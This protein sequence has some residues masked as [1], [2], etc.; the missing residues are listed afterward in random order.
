MAN[1][2]LLGFTG[3]GS[4]DD[5]FFEPIIERTFQQLVL[6]SPSQIEVFK[7]SYIRSDNGK[8]YVEKISHASKAAFSQGAMI[9]CVHTDADANTDTIAFDYKINPA[10]DYVKNSADE[11]C[12]NLCAIVPVYMTEAWLLADKELLKEELF[13]DK[14]N[15]VLGIEHHPE[16]Y[17]DPK[18][19]IQEAINVIHQDLPRK[20]R[21]LT[22][23]DLYQ[24]LGQKIPLEKLHYLLSYRKF[25]EAAKSALIQIN[26]LNP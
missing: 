25:W 21:S 12:K 1:I 5:R 7:P 13:T 16:Q 10:F 23:S 19:I 3:E 26:Y 8:G 9:F 15:D 2:L 4:T 24:P 22:I 17:N 20:R 18:R 6:E 11:T 14:T